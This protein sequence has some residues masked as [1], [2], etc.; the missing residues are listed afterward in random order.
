HVEESLPLELT[1]EQVPSFARDPEDRARRRKLMTGA[2]PV[3]QLL[4]GDAIGD[5]FGAVIE[6]QDAYWI[7]SFVSFD[8]WPV[9]PMRRSEWSSNTAAGMYTDDCEMTVGLIN[10]LVEHGVEI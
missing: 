1:R 3:T 2:S 8:K 6:M 5:A 10:G 9:N 7:R 4:M